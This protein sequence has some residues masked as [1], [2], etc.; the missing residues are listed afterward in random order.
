MINL[1]EIENINF[2]K[3]SFGGYKKESVDAFVD[4]VKELIQSLTDSKKDLESKLILLAGKIEEYRTDEENIRKALLGA[5]RMG[6]SVMKEARAKAEDIIKDATTKADTIISDCKKEQAYEQKVLQNLQKDVSD[7]KTDILS[8]YKG[9]LESISKIPNYGGE[10][11]QT[12]LKVNPEVEKPEEKLEEIKNS[13]EI[14]QQNVE[15]LDNTAVTDGASDDVQ[16]EEQVE[17]KVEDTKLS[18]EVSAE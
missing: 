1:Q 10:P 2:E 12:T 9:H 8:L 13:E 14:E 17:L 15:S 16:P 7:F 11:Q 3:S 5:Q 6:E 18:E 4:D